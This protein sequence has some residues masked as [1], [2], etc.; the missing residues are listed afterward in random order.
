M[1]DERA[2]R[3]LCDDRDIDEK[4]A[5][6]EKLGGKI[7]VPKRE[8]E[9]GAVYDNQR[10]R[11][12]RHSSLQA[13]DVGVNIIS[14]KSAALRKIPTRYESECTHCGTM[15]FSKDVT[16]QKVCTMCNKEYLATVAHTEED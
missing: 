2:N 16:A 11:R 9:S 1:E 8:L 5:M 6:V 13:N 15:N 7:A 3:Q 12:K 10:H 4:I 14:K